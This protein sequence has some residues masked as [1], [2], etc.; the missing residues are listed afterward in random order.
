[1]CVA[2]AA[3]LGAESAITLLDRARGARCAVTLLASAPLDLPG[4]AELRHA[5]LASM[6]QRA[7]DV[8]AIAAAIAARVAGRALPLAPAA[9]HAL[10]ERHWPGNLAE[11]AAVVT[12]A[13]ARAGAAAPE[14]EPEALAPRS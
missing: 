3:R 5:M 6:R 12:A 8:P 9:A 13:V 7:A 4:H 11:L 2:D 1:L 14:L 10:S